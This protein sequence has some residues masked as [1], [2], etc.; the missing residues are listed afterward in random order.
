MQELMTASLLTHVS[1][2]II[3]ILTTI[4]M[5]FIFFTRED[6]ARLTRSYER[7]SLVYFMFLAILIFTGFLAWVVMKFVIT[8]KIIIMVLAVLHMIVTSV[9]LNIAFKRSRVRNLESQKN[10]IMYGRKKYMT[11]T[12]VFIVIGFVAY[13]VHF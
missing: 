4:I 1:F 12:F 10:F 8:F 11:D 6:Y 13:A 2:L 3:T 5:L 7:G 9:K